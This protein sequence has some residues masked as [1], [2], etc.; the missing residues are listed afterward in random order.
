M[1]RFIPMPLHRAGLR[2]V[3]GMRKRWWHLRKPRILGCRVLALDG[4]GQVLLIRH[5]YGSG[6]WMLPGGGVGRNEHAIVGAM[7]E[8]REETACILGEAR[9]VDLVVEDL[10]GAGNQVHVIVG[11]ASGEVKVDGREV[12]E[13]RFYPLVSLPRDI[14]GNLL[15]EIPQW[16]ALYEAHSSES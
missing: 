1:L 12:I 7:R 15:Q 6:K 10:F 2:I 3:H 14:A 13:A 9:E 16:A 8:L 11:R 4:A 5:S